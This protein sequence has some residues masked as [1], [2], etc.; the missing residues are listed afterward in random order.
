MRKLGIGFV[1]SDVHIGG[2]VESFLA[3]GKVEL[4]GAC[5]NNQ[6][7]AE[8]ISDQGN[9]GYSTTDY[10]V[11]LE[12]ET[13][14]IIMVCSPDHSHAEHAIAA[15]KAGK[16]VLCEKPLTTDLQSCRDIVQAVDETG[17]TFMVSQFMRFES[18]YRS[19]K[20]I[21]DQ[22]EIGR[23]F[24]VEGSYIHDMRAYYTPR[25]WRSD[26]DNPQNI[27]IGGGCHPLDLLRWAVGSDIEEVHAYSNGYA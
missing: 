26:P 20:K 9:M 8:N 15:L 1:G 6:K 10:Q 18:V 23:A 22:G 5:N 27:L 24:F 14:D 11:L 2:Y 3:N 25:T 17:L 19:I 16:H 13:V 12:D 21:Y 7:L 4:I